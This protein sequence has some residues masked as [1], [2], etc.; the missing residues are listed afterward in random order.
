MSLRFKPLIVFLL[1]CSVAACTV[2]SPE[3]GVSSPGD[4]TPSEIRDAQLVGEPYV[5]PRY[6]Q[7]SAVNCDGQSRHT[8]LERSLSQ[9]QTTFFEVQVG[10][11]GLVKGAIVPKALEAELETKIQAALGRVLSNTYQQSVQVEIETQPGT[12]YLHTVTWNETKIRGIIEVVYPSGIGRVGFEKL[13]G[14]ELGDRTSEAL[15]CDSPV[16]ESITPEPSIPFPVEPTTIARGTTATNTP[17]P[18]TI[19]T[20]YRPRFSTSVGTGPLAAINFSDGMAEYSDDYLA[21]NHGR[22]QQMNINYTPTGCGIAQYASERIWF[23]STR[24]TTISIN[25]EV[26]AEYDQ[27]TF[28]GS[29][30]GIFDWKVS[31]GDEICVELSSGMEYHINIGPDVDIHYDSYCYRGHC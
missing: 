19:T 29:H 11:G 30:G 24:A 9:G 25:G 8:R 10:I 2:Q 16:V 5:E 28:R 12:A 17:T 6:E 3:P 31:L 21:T 13:I 22:L 7:V 26:I 1:L 15:S 20:P 4:E 27:P 18:V 14:L 23:G